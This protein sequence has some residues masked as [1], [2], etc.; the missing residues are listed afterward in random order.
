MGVE[1]AQHAFT[2]FAGSKS[3]RVNE[4][5]QPAPGHFLRVLHAQGTGGGV[6]GIGKQRQPLLLAG[7]IDLLKY[8]LPD[9]HFASKLC[10]LNTV[11]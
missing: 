2:V 10:F 7:G 6:P 8:I 3:K 11:F 5:L 9:E 4:S 1:V